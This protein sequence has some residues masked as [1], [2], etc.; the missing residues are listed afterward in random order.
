[1]I[2][3]FEGKKESVEEILSPNTEYVTE[4]IEYLKS[5]EYVDSEGEP[6][7]QRLVSSLHDDDLARIV[8]DLRPLLKRNTNIV[9]EKIQGWVHRIDPS[10]IVRISHDEDDDGRFAL[11][12]S[13]R[14]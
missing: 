2:E 9:E 1:M 6:S 13:W 4:L 7:D 12:L 3:S 8:E 5:D 14:K 11:L 10:I